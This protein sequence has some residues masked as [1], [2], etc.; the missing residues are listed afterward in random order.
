[1][2]NKRKEILGIWNSVDIFFIIGSTTFYHF[3]NYFLLC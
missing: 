3:T 2:L 1:M